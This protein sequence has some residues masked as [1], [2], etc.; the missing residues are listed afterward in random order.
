MLKE[1]FL[2]Q[3]ISDTSIFQEENLLS[4]VST[5]NIPSKNAHYRMVIFFKIDNIHEK[6]WYVRDK[7]LW[8][9][10]LRNICYE[11]INKHNTCELWFD[12]EDHLCCLILDEHDV[13]DDKLREI[14][15]KIKIMVYRL[16]Q[17]TISIGIGN[18]YSDISSIQSSYNEAIFS[19]KK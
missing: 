3:L 9:F 12:H 19:L 2:N 4:T 5:F 17:F 6:G 16:L 13:E 1:K 10:A 14:G 11:I 18:A 7:E 15:H 8:G